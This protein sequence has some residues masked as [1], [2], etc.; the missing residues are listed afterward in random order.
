[1]HHNHTTSRASITTNSTHESSSLCILCRRS[2]DT[3][4][5]HTENKKKKATFHA[6]PRTG[7]PRT[8][9]PPAAP[10]ID[11]R[12]QEAAS[13][14]AATRATR[15]AGGK[16]GRSSEGEGKVASMGIECPWPGSGPPS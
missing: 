6:P 13:P 4:P 10:A 2:L 1:Q 8:A 12:A 16:P 9:L 15:H 3:T 7:S 5:L 14:A 11:G